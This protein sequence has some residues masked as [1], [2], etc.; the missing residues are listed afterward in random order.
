MRGQVNSEKGDSSYQIQILNNKA[1]MSNDYRIFR[2][3][4]EMRLK[5]GKEGIYLQN[6][7]VGD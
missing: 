3:E 4:E 6:M 2:Q 7:K 5:A 1:T